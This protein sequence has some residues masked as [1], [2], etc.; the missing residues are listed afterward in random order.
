[1]WK[2]TLVVSLAAQGA[3]A[4]ET[5]TPVNGEQI[6]AALTGHTVFYGNG[7]TQTFSASGDTQ[8][9]SGHLQPGRWRVDGNR[10]CSVWPPSDLWA[11]YDVALGADGQAIRFTAD[12]GSTTDGHLAGN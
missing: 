1:M 9:D 3:L 8:Y 5:W 4:A 2:L 7:A 12:D 6:K 10:Y 11:C